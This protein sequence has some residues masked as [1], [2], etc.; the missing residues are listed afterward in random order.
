MV[1]RTLSVP[2]G[3]DH[4]GMGHR[5]LQVSSQGGLKILIEG[6][7]DDDDN[8]DEDKDGRGRW[9]GPAV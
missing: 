5:S 3:Q 6:D 7:D 8:D 1:S 2:L 9:G 4:A